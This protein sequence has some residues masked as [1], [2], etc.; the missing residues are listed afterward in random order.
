MVMYGAEAEFDKRLREFSATPPS[1]PERS[2]HIPSVGSIGPHSVS[3]LE[4]AGPPTGRRWPS[5]RTKNRSQSKDGFQGVFPGAFFQMHNRL[6]GSGMA[7]KLRCSA[8]RLY[9]ALCSMANQKSAGTFSVSDQT[10]ANDTGMG[11]RTIVEARK[12]LLKFELIESSISPGQSTVYTLKNPSLEWMPVKER[13]RLQCKERGKSAANLAHPEELE[14]IELPHFL[15]GSD[16][17]FARPY[18]GSY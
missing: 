7:A 15:R 5:G 9:T 17:N 4:P 6:F 11:R 1:L 2:I 10:L 3:I 8:G 16:A 18:K 12:K 13:P 14:P